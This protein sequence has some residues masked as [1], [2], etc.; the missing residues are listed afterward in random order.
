MLNRLNLCLTPTAAFTFTD[1]SRLKPAIDSGNGAFVVG[2][3]VNTLNKILLISRKSGSRAW[4]HLLRDRLSDAGYDVGVELTDAVEL[5]GPALDWALGLFRREPSLA[6]P[7]PPL[8]SRAGSDADLVIDLTGAAPPGATPT[9][10]FA[11]CGFASLAEGFGA[12]LG[13]DPPLPELT[14]LLNGVPVGRAAPMLGDRVWLA[15]MA[16]DVLAALVSFAAS[17]VAAQQNGSAQPV[18]TAPAKA[19]R[20]SLIRAYPPVL[21]AGIV[22]R[23]LDRLG[24]R[25]ARTWHVG[26]RKIGS[27]C[28]ADT[29]R[30]DG[31]P[32]TI[33]EDD[34]KRFYADPFVIERNGKYYLFVEE[35]PWSTKKGVIAVC[36][37]DAQGH[38]ERPRVVLEEAHHLSYPQVFAA[39]DMIYMIPESSGGNELVLY[40]AK[41]FPDEWERDAVLIAGANLNDATLLVRDGR[42]WIVATS[43]LSG[44]SASDTMVVYGA[45]SLRGPWK[46]HRTN[47]ILIDRSGARPGGAFIS[48]AGRLTLPIQDGTEG[49][50][51]GLGLRELLTLDDENVVWD[52]VSPIREGTAWPTRRIHTLNRAGPFEVIDGLL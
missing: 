43:C 40:R 12:M 25:R 24:W 47:P 22:G 50:G 45:P 3:I 6:A 21:A 38:C 26:Y 44:G 11:L 33:L 46:P 5:E 35:F 32:F 16:N 29:G 49:Y 19:A 27:V 7:M 36:E 2:S 37:F 30:L 15:R 18:V 51:G 1:Q 39:E 17:V 23:A 28:V 34:G 9:L 41:S 8:Q 20:S 10:T 31:E 4:E 48:R 42:Y 14:A 52:A 13:G